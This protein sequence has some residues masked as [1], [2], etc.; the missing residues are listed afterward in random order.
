MIFDTLP[1]EIAPFAIVIVAI[2]VRAAVAWQRELTWRE[3]VVAHGIKRI[4]FPIL[5]RASERSIKVPTLPLV[6]TKGGHS[7]AEYLGTSQFDTKTVVHGLRENGHEL[8]LVNSLKRRDAVYGSGNE[9]TVAHTRYVHENGKQSE[10]Y[11]FDAP[12]GTDIYCH[13]EPG[14]ESPADHLDV[15]KQVDGDVRGVVPESLF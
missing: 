4:V 14:V 12:N 5:Q 13:H 3:Y 9:Y 11:L 2:L 6:S 15:S 7:D 10:V 1:P 8:H